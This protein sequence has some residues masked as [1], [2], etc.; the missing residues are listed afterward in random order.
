MS[1]PGV[2]E[3]VRMVSPYV[4]GKTIEEV[5]REY[6]LTDVVKLGSNENPYGPFPAALEAM[7]AELDLLN[8]YPDATFEEIKALIGSLYGVS[9]A[10]VAISHGAG[11][12][13]E[14][15]ARTFIEAGDEVIMPRQSYG[16]YREI[17]RLM[18]GE[19]IEVDLDGEYRIDLE[20]IAA[21]V[22]PQTKL[23]WLCNPNNPTGT[24]FDRNRFSALLERLP[25]HCW[26][27]LDEAYAEL[28]DPELLPN[29][30]ACMRDYNLIAVRTF[31]KAW[32]LAGAR[33]G[34]ALA[35]PE[36]IRVIDTVAEPFNANR[37]GLAGAAAA[38]M[39]DRDYCLDVIAR[40]RATRARLT[41]ALERFGWRASV[42]QGNFVFVDTGLDAADLA[43]RLLERGV[44][45]R[46]CG[47]WGYPR[48]LRISIGTDAEIDRLLAVLGELVSSR[49]EQEVRNG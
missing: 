47:G 41:E 7:R 48:H 11:G 1:I 10:E 27:V 5:Q 49:E 29:A 37:I 39:R 6:G 38:L 12:M 2:R 16:L 40:I 9:G 36:V 18:G 44:I 35:R 4:A 13:L 22:G 30:V 32:G 23:I 3:A 34:Y 21:A 8:T 15:L 20:A 25:P 24:L 26:V 31:S 28:A 17:T 46:D 33:L 45:V 19:L 43:R 14:T 42:G